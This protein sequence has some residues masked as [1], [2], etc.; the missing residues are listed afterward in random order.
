M[1][2]DGV[3]TSLEFPDSLIEP[4]ETALDATESWLAKNQPA[5]FREALLALYFRLHSFRRA[6]ELYDEHFVTIIENVLDVKVRLFCLDPSLLLQE[7]AGPRQGGHLLLR[8]AHS[9]GL[10][11]NPPGRGA[12]RSRAA[13]GFAL[14]AR[15]SGGA[16]SRSHPNP[17][18]GPGGI[19][20]RRGGGDWNFGAGTTRQL[21]RLF[22]LVSISQRHT[23]GISDS[24]PV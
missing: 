15:K 10:L 17:F 4:L 20:G 23:P 8:H 18:Q 9:D 3:S 12:G 6:A 13:I 19:A 24:I 2:Q 5:E 21:P 22:P 16:D 14:S 11:S 1:K 7:G